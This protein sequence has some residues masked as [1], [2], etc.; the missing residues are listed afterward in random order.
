M[1]AFKKGDRVVATDAAYRNGLWEYLPGA[2][3]M[4]TVATNSRKPDRVSVVLDG[5]SWP[6]GYHVSFWT[7]AT[8]D[9]GGAT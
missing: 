9:R 3:V 8:P 5:Q 4:G 1:S 6:D 2:P 7:L